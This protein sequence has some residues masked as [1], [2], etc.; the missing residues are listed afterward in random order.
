MSQNMESTQTPPRLLFRKNGRPQAC[1]PCRKR[2]VACDH[3]QPICNRCRKSKRPGEVCEYILGDSPAPKETPRQTRP[4]ESR[5][6]PRAP[7][8]PLTAPTF[9]PPVTVAKFV[10]RPAEV[11]QTESTAETSPVTTVASRSRTSVPASL[12]TSPESIGT[13]ATPTVLGIGYL[14]FTS[15]CGIYE[16][17]RS[18]LNRLQPSG[19]TPIGEIGATAYCGLECSPPLTNQALQTCLT[20]LRYVPDRET[21]L[22][23][24]DCI[25]NPSDGWIRLAAKRMVTSLYETFPQYFCASEKPDDAQLTVLAR[26]ICSNTAKCVSDEETDPEK[27][28]A[29]FTGTNLRWESLGVMFAYWEL[30][31]RCL[32]PYRP[33][34]GSKFQGAD[35]GTKAG[36][37]YRYCVCGT[38]ELTKAAGSGGNSMLLF[39]SAKRAVTESIFSGDASFASWQLHAETM[40]MTTFLGIH[41]EVTTEPYK[42]NICSEIK[43]KLFSYVF[44][45]DKVLASFTGRPP[46]ISRRYARTPP[47]LDLKDEYLLAD[48]ATLARHV[49]ALDEN[50]WNT[51]GGLYSATFVRARVMLA[52]IRDELFEIALGHGPATPVETLLEIKERQLKTVA[53]FPPILAFRE[54]DMQDRKIDVSTL[55]VQLIVHLEHLQNM[56]F[57]ERMLAKRGHDDGAL[58]SVSFEMVSKTVMFWTNMDR[59]ACMNGYFEWLVMAY[60]A[61]GG[62][63]LCLELLKPTLHGGNHPQNPK[64]TRSS[65]IQ[66][67]SLLVGFL[68]WVGPTAPNGDLC[69]DCKCIIQHVLDQALNSSAASASSAIDGGFPAALD[70]MD[71]DFSTQLDFNF[72]LLDTFDWLRPEVPSSQQ[73]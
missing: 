30:A 70:A 29:Q 16:E 50:G 12:P 71:W 73:S 39:M 24:F 35:E 22:K 5:R 60:A 67:L 13:G 1:E 57:I 4:R 40:A 8:L 19:V 25:V 47:P 63:I 48:E 11:S 41:D 64:V 32:G 65:I 43:R 9:P 66:K 34:L 52:H 55:Y 69:A 20:I 18:S 59:L 46:L 15:F 36:A 53:G 51:E 27:W 42:P 31:A 10:P 54:E 38:I 2:K 49:A 56:F 37:Q 61:P 45:M 21:G 6:G 26:A 28:V 7:T 14:G 68:D 17:T 44:Y 23:L 33:D 62:G 58:L 72:D 3:A